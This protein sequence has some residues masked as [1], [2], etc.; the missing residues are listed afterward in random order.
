MV[1]N[2]LNS[3]VDA[4]GEGEPRVLWLPNENVDSSKSLRMPR[5]ADEVR[6]Y[7]WWQ[8]Q[9]KNGRA[10]LV[11]HHIVPE[12]SFLERSTRWSTMRDTKAPRSADETDD[13][14]T[15]VIDE[16]AL[17]VSAALSTPSD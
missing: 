4:G 3:A 17:D 16:I 10:M 6:S 2:G 1:I 14:L 13:R 8:D 7:D 15:T 11:S 12:N 9:A 5:R